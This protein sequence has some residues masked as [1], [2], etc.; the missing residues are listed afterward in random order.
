MKHTLEFQ[1][2]KVILINNWTLIVYILMVMKL[3]N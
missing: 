3:G 2:L 1:F